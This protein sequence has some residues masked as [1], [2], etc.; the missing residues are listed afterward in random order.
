[1][2]NKFIM[3][4]GF[5][6]L[7]GKAATIYDKD[8]K[9]T[10][11]YSS[12]N[13]PYYITCLYPGKT[14]ES[15]AEESQSCAEVCLSAFYDKH[16]Q[17]LNQLMEGK[18]DKKVLLHSIYQTRGDNILRDYRI[19]PITL[20]MDALQFHVILA[21]KDYKVK[22]KNYSIN[23]IRYCSN[24]LI[25]TLSTAGVYSFRDVPKEDLPKV[26]GEYNKLVEQL[27]KNYEE[28]R[29]SLSETDKNVEKKT[30]TQKAKKENSPAKAGKKKG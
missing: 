8:G 21:S 24:C 17:I 9:A 15:S 1:M 14:T 26:K 2:V 27:K 29:S 25:K 7:S 16:E 13:N 18:G 5:A 10:R 12:E 20:A 3:I 4:L 30:K 19:D 11:L 23:Y 22:N 28:K 6:F